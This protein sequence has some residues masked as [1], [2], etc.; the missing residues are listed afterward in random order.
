M[1]GEGK[2]RGKGEGGEI[3]F[4]IF[5][6]IYLIFIYFIMQ[7]VMRHLRVTGMASVPPQ[8][9]ANAPKALT[10]PLTAALA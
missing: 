2:G 3:T 10:P 1:Y 6:F 5:I 9:S 4:F 8:E 7:I